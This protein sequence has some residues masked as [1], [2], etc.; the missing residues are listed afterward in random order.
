LTE[1]EVD[2]I[3]KAIAFKYDELYA[4]EGIVMGVNAEDIINF[5]YAIKEEYL[6]TALIKQYSEVI[7]EKLRKEL[8]KRREKNIS[9][10]TRDIK[11]EADEILKKW[12]AHTFDFKEEN[13]GYVIDR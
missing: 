6:V 10:N 13:Q 7:K 2:G 4:Y 3:V 12:D 1:E 8:T 9:K 11:L 5:T